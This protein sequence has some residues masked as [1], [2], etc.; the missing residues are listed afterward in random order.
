MAP[1]TPIEAASLSGKPSSVARI[2]VPKMPNCPAAPSSTICGCESSGLKSIIAPTPMKISSGNSSLLIPALYNTS[3]KPAF[4]RHAGDGDV[5][6]DAAKADRQQQ[7]RLV[8]LDD[9]QRDQ[10]E[11]DQD[12]HGVTGGE[13][14][15][16]FGE[17]G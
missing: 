5:G 4:V 14:R 7:H 8:F 16:A 12:H 6:Q 15:K 17:F 2:S 10:H 13:V 9:G 1:I 11:T 3:N